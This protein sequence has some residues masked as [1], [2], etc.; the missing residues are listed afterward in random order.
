MATSLGKA[1]NGKLSRDE[2]VR[3]ALALADSEGLEALSI[4][5]IA[6]RLGV[7]PMALYRHVATKEEIL[8]LVVG[9]M[10]ARE[11]EDVAWPDGW[12]DILRLIATRLRKLLHNAVVLDTL[13]RRPVTGPHAFDG[14]EH[15]L[16]ALAREGLDS[17]T[18][19]GVYGNT[20]AFTFGHA[21]LHVGRE[22]SRAAAGL[23]AVQERDRVAEQIAALPANDYP[24]VVAAGREVPELFGEEFF[25]VGV[26]R[27]IAGVRSALAG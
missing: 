10:L 21:A 20:V 26:E 5:T 12:A 27:I 17:H 14:M 3:T 19:A 11:S 6:S 9:H 16:A 15:L 18:A 24:Q 22:R 7:S 2:I 13:Q 4:R 25:D 1:A 23:T 8:D